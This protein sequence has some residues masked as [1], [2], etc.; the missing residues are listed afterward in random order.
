MLKKWLKAWRSP[1][2]KEGGDKVQAARHPVALDIRNHAVLKVLSGLHRAG[3]EAYLVGGAVRDLLL[4]K[5]PKDFDVAT[6]ALPEQVRSVFKRS[7]II[8]RRFQIV[9][10]MVGAETIEVSTFRGGGNVKHNESGRIVRD[11]AYGTLAQDA[12]RRDFTCNALYYDVQNQQIIDF[13]NGL[14]DIRAKRL[15]M[16]GDAAERYVEDPVRILRAIRLSGKLGLTLDEATAAPLATHAVLLRHEPVS[17][18]FDE[19]LKILLSG[20]A[21]GCLRQ[22]Q[23]CGLQDIAIHPMLTAML[24][25]AE[26]SSLHI[27]VPALTQT[28]ERLR[29]GKS[30]SVGFIL[31]ALFWDELNARWQ[32][33]QTRESPIAAMN[34]AMIQLRGELERGWGVPQRF[35]ATMREI[36]QLQPLF[37]YRR[38]QRAFRLL[39]QARF[40]AAYDFLCLRARIE[41][42]LSELA[43]WWTKFQSAGSAE[44]E[45]MVQAVSETDAEPKKKC[46]RRPRRKKPAVAE[47]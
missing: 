10:V 8:G 15:V 5:T 3:F 17:R 34:S 30:V 6:N 31:A 26:K 38:G 23:A 18:L 25:A 7:R 47:S 41:P 43:Q 14:A 28:D 19:L 13:H 44:R 42:D 16:I 45:Q 24:R 21:A 11:N 36:W 33:A 40:R 20:H 29:E 2:H 46:R 1:K 12:F 35:S 37:A 9:H 4:G 39:S 27:C 32:D 22:F